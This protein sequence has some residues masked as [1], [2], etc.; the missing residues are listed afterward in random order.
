VQCLCHIAVEWF[1]HPDM[2]ETFQYHKEMIE[3]AL[4]M[5]DAVRTPF[6]LTG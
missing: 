5:T 1:G 2:S 4:F 3:A 6:I